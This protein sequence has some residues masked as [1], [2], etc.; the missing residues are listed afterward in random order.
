MY[1]N[2]LKRVVGRRYI[3]PKCGI[4]LDV[5]GVVGVLYCPN[6]SSIM[7]IKEDIK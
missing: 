5:V 2:N 6:C 4:E 7:K 1:T 3:C